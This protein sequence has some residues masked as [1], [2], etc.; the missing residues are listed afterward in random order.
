MNE[1]EYVLFTIKPYPSHDG[2]I[3]QI[4]KG[5][6][7]A[8]KLVFSNKKAKDVILETWWRSLLGKNFIST[9]TDEKAENHL[10]QRID[11]DFLK[12]HISNFSQKFYVCGPEQIV[13]DINNALEDLGANTETITFEK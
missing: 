9:L 12:T 11:K 6:V 7:G 4:A 1:G 5:K 10:H 2:V 8:N 13:K 3:E